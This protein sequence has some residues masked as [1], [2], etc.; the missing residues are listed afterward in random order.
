MAKAKEDKEPKPKCYV[1]GIEGEPEE[2]IKPSPKYPVF[3]HFRCNGLAACF[4]C[5]GVLHP[6]D[7]DT[8]SSHPNATLISALLQISRHHDCTVGSKSFR[9]NPALKHSNFLDYFRNMEEV[10]NEK[11]D[12]PTM[13]TKD[14]EKKKDKKDKR[15]I[16]PG[17]S[18]SEKIRKGK[19]MNPAQKALKDLLGRVKYLCH[20]DTYPSAVTGWALTQGKHNVSRKDAKSDV[21]FKIGTKSKKFD[22]EGIKLELESMI[23]GAADKEE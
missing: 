12:K 22:C 20:M 5:G 23:E 7:Y 3:R 15:G 18:V 16:K 21:V 11:G 4:V 6:S 13:G 8:K 17:E 9:T 2:M 10:D 19:K 14:I 1:C